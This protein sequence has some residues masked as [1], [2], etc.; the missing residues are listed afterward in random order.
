[1]YCDSSYHYINQNKIKAFSNVRINDGDSLT[2]SAN[3]LIYNGETKVSFLNGNIILKDRYTELHTNEIEL[4]LNSNIAYCN[5]KSAIYQDGVTLN[6][7]KGKYNTKS[8]MFYF[9]DNVNVHSQKYR[10]ETDTLHFNSKS[11]IA[12]FLGP[13]YIFSK[14]NTIYCENGWYNTDTDKSQ[15]NKNAYIADQKFI[16]QGDS[17]FYNRNKGYGKAIDN[18]KMLDT[19]NNITITGELSEYFEEED[20]IEISKKSLVNIQLNQDSVMI[21]AEKFIGFQEKEYII[22]YNNV[23]IYNEDIQGISDSLSYN[24]LDSTINLYKEPVIWMDDIQ[25][26]SDI[27]N[28]LIK[29]KEVHIINF[30][31]KPIIISEVDS[32]HFNQIKGKYISALLNDNELVKL[33]VI[34]NGESLF[35]VQEDNE[36][37]IGINK[38]NCSNITIHIE[39]KEIK[40]II[41]RTKP[42]SNTIPYN[43]IKESQKFLTGFKWR[44]NER[45][46]DIE[47]IIQ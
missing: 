46:S 27:I 34:G 13:S 38:A 26:N 45:P 21:S 47:D 16:I 5:E 25:V 23:K 14:N 33:D 18:V 22:A 9:K 19:T 20:K 3:Q 10:I 6:T 11:K 4:N 24:M 43:Q 42:K 31:I 36:Q 30:N 28:I 12:F 37:K 7:N 35:I 41:Y 8:K 40:D 15:F 1:M 29:N 44:I 2:I 17:L 39:E 32:L